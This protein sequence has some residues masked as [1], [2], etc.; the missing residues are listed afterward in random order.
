MS[1]CGGH[2]AVFT[3]RLPKRPNRA[4][5]LLLIGA[6]GAVASLAQAGTSPCAEAVTTLEI[7]ECLADRRTAVDAEMEIAYQQ[8]LNFLGQHRA[9]DQ[10]SARQARSSLEQAQRAWVRFRKADCAAIYALY[11]GG[12]IRTAAWLNCMTSRAVQ[13]TQQ[14]RQFAAQD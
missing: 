8:A 6:A 7:N 3:E 10:P 14:L 9:P 12:S 5:S 2:L 13:R 11:A 4:V 1:K